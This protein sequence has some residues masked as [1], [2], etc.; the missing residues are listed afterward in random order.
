MS[1]TKTPETPA[2]ST[3]DETPAAAAPPQPALTPVLLDLKALLPMAASDRAQAAVVEASELGIDRTVAGGR[4]MIKGVL[5]DANGKRI[6][7]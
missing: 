3:P 7:S 6:N 1:T 2:A 4:Y 5:Y